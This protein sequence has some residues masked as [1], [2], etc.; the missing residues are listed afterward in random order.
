LGD[1]FAYDIRNTRRVN[2]QTPLFPNSPTTK[3]YPFFLPIAYFSQI[4]KVKMEQ[5]EK[6]SDFQ[7]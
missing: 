7:K 6:L 2:S 1:Y 3:K 4:L 5:N